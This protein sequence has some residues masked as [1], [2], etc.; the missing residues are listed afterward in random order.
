MAKKTT[1]ELQTELQEVIKKHNEASNIMQ[2][3]KTRAIQ[4]EAILND[5]ATP[6]SDA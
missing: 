3:C 4:I 2:Q 1:K 6:E 5:R